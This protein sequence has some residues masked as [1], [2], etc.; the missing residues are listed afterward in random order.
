VIGALCKKE[1]YLNGMQMKINSKLVIRSA[2]VDDIDFLIPLVGE[3]SG[4]VWP[5]IWNTIKPDS[6]TV[7]EFATKYMSDATKKLSIGN[8]FIGEQGGESVAALIIYNESKGSEEETEDYG[9]SAQLTKALSPY[10]ELSDLDSLFISELCTTPAA[11]G[12]GIGPKMLEYSKKMAIKSGYKSVTLRVY[13]QN[14]L[15]IKLY[16]RFGFVIIDQRSVLPYPGITA[17]GDVDNS[18]AIR[19]AMSLLSILPRDDQLLNCG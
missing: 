11:R 19:I 10:T 2:T 8:T 12:K 17:T 1:S 9:V 7:L 18:Q 4:G 14:K 5:A 6:D 3:S 13:S 15:A 16:A